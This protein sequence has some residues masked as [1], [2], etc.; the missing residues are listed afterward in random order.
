MEKKEMIKPGLKTS[1]GRGMLGGGLVLIALAAYQILTGDSTIDVDKLAGLANTSG[2]IATIYTATVE[3]ARLALA[4][5]GGMLA[6]G[7]W[8][9]SNYG[10]Y[11][12]LLKRALFSASA[13]L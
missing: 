3:Q 4:G 8:L 7:V 6:A 13:A 10:R 5:K 11:R 9:V 1:E 12:T 2:E